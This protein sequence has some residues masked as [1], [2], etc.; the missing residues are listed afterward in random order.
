[1]IG[2]F[3]RGMR[4]MRGPRAAQRAFQPTG[5]PVEREP[6]APGVQKSHQLRCS[7]NDGVSASTASNAEIISLPRT[8]VDRIETVPNHRSIGTDTEHGST[9]ISFRTTYRPG[10]RSE[11]PDECWKY[12]SDPRAAKLIGIGMMIGAGWMGLVWAI[13]ALL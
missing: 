5:G 7:P 3:M 6:G 10:W 1:M 9:V 13:F 12:N 2:L 4:G 11:W 8:F